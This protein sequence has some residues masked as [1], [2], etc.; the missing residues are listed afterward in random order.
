MSDVLDRLKAALADR[1]AVERE[2]GSGGMATVYLAEDLKY[3]RQ[4]AV[5]VLKPELAH[6]VGAGRFLREIRITAQLNH[7]HILP[8]LDSGEA[9]GFLYFV[10]PYVA[11]ESLRDRLDREGRLPID[12]ALRVAEQVASAL[13]HAHRNEVIHRDIKPENILLHEGE[14]MVADFGIA[15]AV[16]AAGGERLT[17]TGIAVGTPAFMSP[18][19]A[20]GDEQ[21]DERSDIYSLGCVLYEMLGGE[22]PHKGSTPREILA[23]KLLSKAPSIRELRPEADVALEAVLARA[24]EAAP[25]DRF[26]TAGELGE[27]LRSPEVGWTIAAKRLRA[28]RRKVVAGS[29]AG[30]VVLVLAVGTVLRYLRGEPE[31]TRLVVLPFE[32][33]SVLPDENVLRAVS[34]EIHSRLV[35]IEAVD[36]IADLSARQARASGWTVGEIG[37]QLEVDWIL[38]G[39]VRQQDGEGRFRVRAE[40]IRVEDATSVW[41]RSYDALALEDLLH[42]EIDVAQSIVDTL[43]LRLTGEEAEALERRYTQ[44]SEAYQL[45]QRGREYLRRPGTLRQKYESAQ[46]LFESALALDPEF[47]LAYAGLSRVHGWMH[48]YYYDPSPARV[49]RQREA[50]EAALRL[51]P[52]L[53]EAHAAMGLWYYWAALDYEQALAEFEVAARGRPND[54]PLW[55]LIG[56]VH[57]RA[58]DYDRALAAYYRARELDPLN[59]TLIW[60]AGVTYVLLRRY[61]EAVRDFERALTLAPDL[62]GVTVVR[63]FTYVLWQGQLDSLRSALDRIPT[64]ADLGGWG[65]A[66]A[67][68]IQLLHW[69]RQADSLLVSL[70][71]EREPILRAPGLSYRP[72]SLYAGWAHQ[73]RGDRPA[74]RAAFE[75]AL[76]LVDSILTEQPENWQVHVARGLALAGLDRREDALREARWLQQS[77]RYQ[78]DFVWGTWIGQNLAEIL[79]QAGE[80]EAA[81]D[82]LERLLG[83][84]SWLSVRKLRLEP[85]YDPLRDHPRFRALLARYE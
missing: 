64:G 13:E 57:R 74:A 26:A 61:A 5:K 3:Q 35:A 40:L 33:S 81:I 67:W 58:G 15:V 62:R 2:L 54:R 29:A 75:S 65:T 43:Q 59:A 9:D 73:L 60:E 24:L 85:L 48:H 17:E 66:G 76:V 18:E 83:Q 82:E 28:R 20:S 19:Q 49:A 25:E 8:L 42:A 6:A 46:Q 72:S 56:A 44:D 16:S 53:P 52:E 70:A 50:A 1:Y 39:T 22:P 38:D 31:P 47:A 32:I 69:E 11:G 63:G 55:T 34:E 7:P 36:P 84:P 71:T 77:D 10:M 12:E 27:A 51:A 30:L 21:V 79:A 80:A 14:P 45:Y 37:E 23:Q 78:R 68:R 41:E 4:V